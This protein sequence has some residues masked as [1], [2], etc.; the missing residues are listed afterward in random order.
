MRRAR[1]Y[2]MSRSSSWAS[3]ECPEIVWLFTS[4][5]A[6]LQLVRQ[7]QGAGAGFAR[8]SALQHCHRRAR[9][10][11]HRDG[12]GNFRFSQF[13]SALG[14]QFVTRA[15]I[16]T[17]GKIYRG[18]RVEPVGPDQGAALGAVERCAQPDRECAVSKC[19]QVMAL[20]SAVYENIPIVRISVLRLHQ[21]CD[22]S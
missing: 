10:V 1:P 22:V 4:Q 6:R 2:K 13:A 21:T 20:G 18:H 7:G 16:I 12:C 19:R 17:H 15:Q 5:T 11:A 14:P 9:H 3:R 8:H